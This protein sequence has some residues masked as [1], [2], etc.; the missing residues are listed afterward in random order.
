M[1]L[2]TGKTIISK[3]LEG[4][5]GSEET[6]TPLTDKLPWVVL[7]MKLAS[8]QEVNTSCSLMML[9]LRTVTFQNF[10]LKTAVSLLRESRDKTIESLQVTTN[11]GTFDFD[12]RSEVSVNVTDADFSI[13][14]L[15]PP[16]D[17]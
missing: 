11:V 12:A 6:D 7:R 1:S 15:T 9:D 17:E 13:V 5:L 8:G 10:P 16:R 2:D 3:D 14:S 4:I